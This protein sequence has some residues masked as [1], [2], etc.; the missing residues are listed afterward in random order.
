[1]KS[2]ELQNFRPGSAVRRIQRSAHMSKW[3]LVAMGQAGLTGWARQFVWAVARLNVRRTGRPEEEILSIIGAAF[4]AI[5]LI[6]FLREVAAFIA[7]QRDQHGVPHAVSCRAMGISP[8]WLD[9]WLHGDCSSR[10]GPPGG[11]GGG[12]GA[13]VPA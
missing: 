3:N 7:A 8:A 5:A 4:L 10:R 11:A 1:M 2:A 6:N 13:P 9:K 12:G